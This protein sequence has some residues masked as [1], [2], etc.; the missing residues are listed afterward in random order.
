MAHF[1]PEPRRVSSITFFKR[2]MELYVFI[3]R[4]ASDLL[5]RCQTLLLLRIFYLRLVKCVD[6][7]TRLPPGIECNCY[8]RFSLQSSVCKQ[9]QRHG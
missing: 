2:L 4:G 5:L 1:S 8:E 6:G 9:K 3:K 7:P